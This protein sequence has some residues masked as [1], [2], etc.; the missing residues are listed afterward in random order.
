MICGSTS[1]FWYWFTTKYFCLNE[2]NFEEMLKG[3][4]ITLL[5]RNTKKHSRAVTKWLVDE[6]IELFERIIEKTHFKF[7]L[8]IGSIV[9]REFVLF[10]SVCF[11]FL[12]MFCVMLAILI[13]VKLNNLTGNHRDFTLIN[14]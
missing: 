11:S 6:E 4:K 12:C 2:S 1:N 10:K 14:I 8:C 9:Q 13:C 5:F 7:S 3:K